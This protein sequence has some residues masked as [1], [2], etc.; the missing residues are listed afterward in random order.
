MIAATYNCGCPAKPSSP[1]PEPLGLQ[2]PCSPCCFQSYSTLRHSQ[3]QPAQRCTQFITIKKP[4]HIYP[5]SEDKACCCIN[6]KSFLHV[7]SCSEY[8]SSVHLSLVFPQYS[9]CCDVDAFRIY[10]TPSRRPVSAAVIS[11]TKDSMNKQFSRSR[12]ESKSR[13]LEM[14]NMERAPT[15]KV[16]SKIVGKEQPYKE[17]EAIINDNRVIIRMQ[18]EPVK[19]EYDP[20]CECIGQVAS[21][22]SALNQR[23]CDDGVVFDMA[24]GNLELCRTSREDESAPSMEKTCEEAGCRTVTLYPSVKDDARGASTAYRMEGR[25]VKRSKM[26]RPIDLEENPN[27]FLLRIRKHCDSGDKRQT[28]DLEFRAPRPWLP[29]KEKDL[30]KPDVLEEHEDADKEHKEHE[31]DTDKEHEHEINKEHKDDEKHEDDT[32]EKIDAH[33]KNDEWKI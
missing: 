20:P 21:K 3:I 27:I 22:E 18:K 23:K 10:S 15:D 9:H 4:K 7:P 6:R 2:A 32:D 12:S 17:I 26:V 28:I 33:E 29:K 1:I 19:E 30:L 13:N 31:G 24:H 5:I 11:A 14:S 8:I 25:E 16:V